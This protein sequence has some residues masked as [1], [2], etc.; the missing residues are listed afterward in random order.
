MKDYHPSPDLLKQ[1]VCSTVSVE[2]R[3]RVVRHLLSGCPSCRKVTREL[4]LCGYKLP[5]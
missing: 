4:W 1:F 5:W 3:R 2:E